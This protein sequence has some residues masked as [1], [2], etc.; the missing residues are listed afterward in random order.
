M[1]WERKVKRNGKVCNLTKFT[2][3]DII[4]YMNNLQPK[5][6]P[7][8]S[9][10]T[11]WL[12]PDV[13]S[14]L[15]IYATYRKLTLSDVGEEI[16]KSALQIIRVTI[17]NKRVDKKIEPPNYDNLNKVLSTA[18]KESNGKKTEIID[19]PEKLKKSFAK[20]RKEVSS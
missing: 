14:L 1:E 17:N 4:T 9:R 7:D 18:L 11:L 13:N 20:I 5:Y 3:F 10:T 2:T 12:D 8:K 6:K 19:T 15:K 16:L